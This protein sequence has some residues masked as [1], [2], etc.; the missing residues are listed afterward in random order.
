M[1][2]LIGS[3]GVRDLAKREDKQVRPLR[4]FRPF[5]FSV[6]EQKGA[7]CIVRFLVNQVNPDGCSV[8]CWQ[9]SKFPLICVAAFR[10]KNTQYLGDELPDI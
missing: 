1:F 2:K 10:D 6:V 8:F 4:G 5:N 9:N 3:V 7:T